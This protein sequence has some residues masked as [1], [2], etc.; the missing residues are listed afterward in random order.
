MMSPERQAI[1]TMV[2]L[3]ERGATDQAWAAFRR[4]VI[5]NTS[6]ETWELVRKHFVWRGPCGAAYWYNTSLSGVIE[7]LGG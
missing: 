2:L 5:S 6:E 3:M 7:A 4:Y 1:V